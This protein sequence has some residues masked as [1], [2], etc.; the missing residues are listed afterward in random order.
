I[1]GVPNAIWIILD[2]ARNKNEQVLAALDK[3]PLD[4]MEV[5]QSLQDA[6]N[7]TDKAVDQTNTMLEQAYMIEQV[8]QY[9]N[10]YRSSY[11]ILHRKL[12]EDENLLRNAQY[13]LSH[14]QAAHAQEEIEHE[15]LKKDKEQQ[16]LTIT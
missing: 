14:E 10:R 9:A 16:T 7:S 15:T 3:Q 8:I 12:V 6:K 2:E 5:N 4:I 13:E 11:P 1:P